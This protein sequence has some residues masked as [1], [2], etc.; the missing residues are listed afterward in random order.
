MRGP[1]D[2]PAVRPSERSLRARTAMVI[3]ALYAAWRVHRQR[4]AAR[5]AL[6]AL[7]DRLLDDLGLVRTGAARPGIGPRQLACPDPGRTGGWCR[8]RP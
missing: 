8:R 7:P 3:R 5:R 2:Q 6:A 4:A 1:L